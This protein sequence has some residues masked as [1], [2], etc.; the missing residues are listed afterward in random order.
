MTT[1]GLRAR[2]PPARR[3]VTEESA[4][5]FGP[6]PLH[7]CALCCHGKAPAEAGSEMLGKCFLDEARAY[8]VT[9]YLTARTIA[10]LYPRVL[11]AL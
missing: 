4:H 6:S 7:E 10:A 3:E 1:L 8:L 5:H 11:N 9:D 2:S